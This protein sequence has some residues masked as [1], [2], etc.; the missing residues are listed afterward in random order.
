[1][2]IKVLI[3][4]I[5]NLLHLSNAYAQSGVDID[6]FEESLPAKYC[7]KCMLVGDIDLKNNKLPV[8]YNENPEYFNQ[9]Y[10]QILPLIN[11]VEFKE[12]STSEVDL[13]LAYTALFKTCEKYWELQQRK[14]GKKYVYTIGTNTTLVRGIN[15]TKHAISPLKFREFLDNK[16]YLCNQSDKYPM[17]VQSVETY[18]QEVA[19]IRAAQEEKL[20]QDEYYRRR[21]AESERRMAELRAE[22]LRREEKAQELQ[23]NMDQLK[24]LVESYQNLKKKD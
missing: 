5:A 7:S 6:S 8:Y 3:I 23:E 22:Q 12:I 17:R 15:G 13:K 24:G 20:R 11:V 2:N 19:K 16:P 10:S 1:M 9:Y 18:K 21:A 4:L 14:S